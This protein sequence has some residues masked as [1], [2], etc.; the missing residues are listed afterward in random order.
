MYSLALNCL[1]EKSWERLKRKAEE[2]FK[3]NRSRR[4][5]QAFFNILNETFAYQYLITL[6]NTNVTL[7]SE[8]KK[9][10][11]P[12]ISYGSEVIQYCE[13]KTIIIS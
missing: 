10:K 9:H 8:R 6:G 7:L 2:M 4:G 12:D 11:T 1:D 13:V 3:E 5:K